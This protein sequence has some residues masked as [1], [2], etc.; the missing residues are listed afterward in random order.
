MRENKRRRKINR[1]VMMMMA[2]I[3]DLRKLLVAKSFDQISLEARGLP[4]GRFACMA[5]CRMSHGA[6]IKGDTMQR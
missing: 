4:G 6:L 1:Q 2:K 5:E 3:G